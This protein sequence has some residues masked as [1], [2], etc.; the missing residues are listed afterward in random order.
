MMSCAELITM[1]LL[2]AK[3][4][5]G[6]RESIAPHQLSNQDLSIFQDIFR[7]ADKN[8]DGKLSFE[9]F[10]SYFSDGVLNQDELK[11]MFARIDSQ[12]TNNMDTGR[13]CDYFSEYLG[14]YRNVLSALEN[15]NTT[16]LTAMDKTKLDYENSSQIEQ[17]VTRFLIR[18]TMNQLH[19]LQNSLESALETIEGQDGQERQGVRKAEPQRVGRRCNRRNQKSL[20][21]SP[22]D[23]YSGILT[24]GLPV[25]CDSQW[26]AQINRLQQLIDKLE[27]TS[28]RLEPL[29][30][31]V[32]LDV[33]E[34]NILVAQRQMA[35]NENYLDQFKQSLRRYMELTTSQSRC[36]HISAQRL[37]PESSFVLYEIWEDQES[38]NS[39]LQSVQSKTFQ[40]V[41]IDYLESPEQTRTMLFP[42]CWW[43]LSHI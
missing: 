30:E 10:Q 19:S 25:D 22:T 18:E 8:D 31:E 34:K 37:R 12:Q 9:E 1:C 7:R 28:P 33:A 23:P 3:H 40:R 16:I 38:W 35:V 32:D 15:L 13:L 2:S 26:S 24:T 41:I 21:L 11:N 17:F 14:E 20:C 43:N 4:S 5:P 36:L 39:H 6:V 29:K 27:Y 42:A